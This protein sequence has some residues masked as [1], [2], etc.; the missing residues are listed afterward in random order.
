MKTRIFNRT[1]LGGAASAILAAFFTLWLSAVPASAADPRC[2][3][4][5][6]LSTALEQRYAE[7]PVAV[8]LI[9]Q[10]TVI[11]IYA[12][13]DGDSW[14]IV[15]SRADGMSCILGAG[16]AWHLLPI[17]LLGPDA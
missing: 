6:D 11:E 5:N 2:G 17:K 4:R 14:T 8:G 10:R 15:T 13:A 9:D 1:R 7:V 12:R 16:K 3:A